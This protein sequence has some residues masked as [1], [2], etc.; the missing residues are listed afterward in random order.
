MTFYLHAKAR[1]FQGLLPERRG[2][3]LA[4]TVLC[5]LNSLVE[6]GLPQA[7][8]KGQAHT[9]CRDSVLTMLLLSLYMYV[10]EFVY[11]GSVLP[12]NGHL[13]IPNNCVKI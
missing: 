4:V 5:V 8:S 11:I 12:A 10:H 6:T 3:N 2:Q 1:R 9:P 13:F 7:L